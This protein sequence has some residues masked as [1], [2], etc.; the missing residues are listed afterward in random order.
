MI[1]GIAKLGDV[2]AVNLTLTLTAPVSEW[3]LMAKQMPV[4]WPNGPMA[5]VINDAIRGVLQTTEA[6]L[7]VES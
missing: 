3:R 5:S 7:E 4:Q 6:A 1:K 2:E